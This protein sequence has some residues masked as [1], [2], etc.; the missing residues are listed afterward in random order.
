M[1]EIYLGNGGVVFVDDEDYDN[2]SRYNWSRDHAGYAERRAA[3][4]PE[5]EIRMHRQIMGY[6][7]SE[8]D[9]CDRNKLNNQKSNLRLCTRSQNMANGNIRS[10]N[11]SGYRGVSKFRDKWQ[12]GIKKNY[13][14]VCLG[15]SFN[16]PEEAAMAYD[17]AAIK[18]FGEFASTNFTKYAD[19]VGHANK[20]RVR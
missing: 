3:D 14:K 15:H 12:A 20:R 1:K 11:T 19:P 13:K 2:L 5:R 7:K 17:N 4:R 18:L 6:P 10:N 16:T 8:I 9:H